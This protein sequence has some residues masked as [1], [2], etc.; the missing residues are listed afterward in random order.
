MKSLLYFL[1]CVLILDKTISHRKENNLM[2]TPYLN[3]EYAT[4]RNFNFVFDLNEENFKDF[5]LMDFLFTRNNT[6]IQNY[7]NFN[8]CR[9]FSML[10]SCQEENYKKIKDF[11][12]YTLTKWGENCSEVINDIMCYEE[13]NYD[14]NN[15]KEILKYISAKKID[16]ISRISRISHATCYNLFSK[17]Y[18]DKETNIT[19]NDSID[20]CE[21]Q[22]KIPNLKLVVSE[23][24]YL[25]INSEAKI[26]KENLHSAFIYLMRNY[27]EI[28]ES[29]RFNLLENIRIDN[30]I[31]GSVEKHLFVIL[32]VLYPNF[33][34]VEPKVQV[35]SMK[36]LS[37]LVEWL[38]FTDKV[39]KNTQNVF[40]TQ[41]Q[42]VRMF[43][44]LSYKLANLLFSFEN[45]TFQ[46]LSLK[47]FFIKSKELDALLL[48][49]ITQSEDD[50]FLSLFNPEEARVLDLYFKKIHYYLWPGMRRNLIEDFSSLL[51]S[52]KNF[53]FLKLEEVKTQENK[54]KSFMRE[55]RENRR[56]LFNNN[57]KNLNEQ[58]QL[59]NHL[60]ILNSTFHIKNESLN[61][62]PRI[63][64]D[65]KSNQSELHTKREKKF[66]SYEEKT[67]SKFN[68]SQIVYRES[69]ILASSNKTASIN[70]TNIHTKN[71]TKNVL[72]NNHGHKKTNTTIKKNHTSHESVNKT[73]INKNIKKPKNKN[74]HTISHNN[75]TKTNK[76]KKHKKHKKHKNKTNNANKTHINNSNVTKNKISLE[77]N[78]TLNKSITN[79]TMRQ[80]HNQ[81][82]TNNSDSM[83]NETYYTTEKGRFLTPLFLSKELF[84]RTAFD[85]LTYDISLIGEVVIYYL[86][87]ITLFV[88]YCVLIKVLLNK[89]HE[90]FLAHNYKLSPD[91]YT[92]LFTYLGLFLVINIIIG[93][94]LYSD[95]LMI[96]LFAIDSE[97][98]T[99]SFI[100]H[101]QYGKAFGP[102][103]F[104]FFALLVSLKIF[105]G[106]SIYIKIIA[107]T[108]LTL[109]FFYLGVYIGLHKFID[110]E[111]VQ[112]TGKVRQPFQRI[113]DDSS[114]N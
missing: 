37:H 18:K 71:L 45:E 92:H 64:N 72:N 36:I 48:T 10:S 34:F 21:N 76:T 49:V 12:T 2:F 85:L 60:N 52:L 99:A 16:R 15:E 30:L 38:K 109:L 20:F 35:K 91:N 14:F 3:Y 108:I 13:C 90:Y 81:S 113:N 31:N 105:S 88:I 63:I 23:S 78:K 87:I 100:F 67:I 55:I 32:N 41:T 74:N 84:N 95:I 106:L 112:G 96:L 57:E 27:L 4:K 114:V 53:V 103:A 39:Y 7:E 46:L 59:L 79:I 24:R 65:F 82:K 101:Y 94:I 47:T 110:Y 104:S 26:K 97:L 42:Y 68:K 102:M 111:R 44:S 73:N 62:R 8:V 80:K 86:A 17:C 66:N 69:L 51:G 93:Y 29:A 43:I 83:S 19:T 58:H 9:P 50:S 98:L 25:N 54:V 28:F 6:K 1:I 61:K 70:S 75:Y 22:I 56:R 11:Q 77:P 5:L 89:C 107:I 33:N 40:I